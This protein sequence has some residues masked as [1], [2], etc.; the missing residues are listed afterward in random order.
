MKTSS[1]KAKGRRCSVDAKKFLVEK[2]GIK[3]DHIT[4][5]PSGVPGDDL[6]LTEEAKLKFPFRIENKNTE[7]L[8]IWKAFEQLDKRIKKDELKCVFFKRNKSDLYIA[9]LANDLSI[10]LEIIKY[11]TRK[12]SEEKNVSGFSD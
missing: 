12:L 6:V 9:M 1:A 2:I 10:F 7:K 4:V 3:E 5:T 8:N 11:Q